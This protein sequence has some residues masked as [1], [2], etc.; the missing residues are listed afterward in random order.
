MVTYVQKCFFL[1]KIL[2]VLEMAVLERFGENV[3]KNL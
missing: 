1:K 3:V 2:L